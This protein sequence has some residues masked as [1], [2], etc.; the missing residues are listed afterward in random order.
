MKHKQTTLSTVSFNSHISPLTSSEIADV[1][2][3]RES[4]GGSLERIYRFFQK[5]VYGNW[6]F[7]KCTL[8]FKKITYNC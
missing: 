6:F 3:G 1:K 8:S 7:L 4:Y 2:G 5:L